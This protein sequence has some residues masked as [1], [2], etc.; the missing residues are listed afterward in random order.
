VYDAYHLY[1]ATT[2][3]ALLQSAQS[4]YNYSNGKVKQSTD[5]NGRLLKNL[6]DGLG[7]LKEVD[8]S[9]ASAPTTY[10]TSTTYAYSDTAPPSIH[11]TDYLTSATT[12]DTW[13]Y[14]DGF[15]RLE[16]ERRSSQTTNVFAVFGRA[17][18]ATGLLASSSLPYFSSGSASTS[19]STTQALYTT[20]TL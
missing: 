1:P 5:P 3:N 14:F 12:T 2:T 11:R 6:Y 7:R 18:N 4:Y 20:Y 17:Y 19:P 9:D 10:A 16:Q 13:D 8:Q 15:N